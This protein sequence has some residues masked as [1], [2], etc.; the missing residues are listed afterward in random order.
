[1]GVTNTHDAYDRSLD[2]WRR[3][4]DV[5]EGRD[6]VLAQIKLGRGHGYLPRLTNQTDAEYVAYAERAAF[7]N[8][9]GRTLDAFTGMIFAKDPS[10]ELPTALD[11]Y[12]NDITLTA[13]NLREFSEQVV[14]QQIAV[15]RVGIMV[16]YPTEVP[17]SVSVADAE[18]MNLRPFLRLYRAE[19]IINWR[20]ANVNGA[21]VLTLVVLTELVDRLKDEFTV[22]QVV[23]YRVLSLEPDGYRVRVMT[24][25]G[26]IISDVYPL[27]RGAR[28]GF[29]PFVVLGVNSADVDV[30]K[31]PLLD[32]VDTNL[33]HFRNSAD[34]E[35]GLHFTGLP[36]PYVAGI[37][38][39]EG[40]SL[41]VGSTTAWVF[42]DPA[43]KAEFLEFKG[44][45]LGTLR[46]ALKDKEQR[47]AVLGARMLADDKRTAEAFGTIELKTAGERS[48]L[49]SIS[50]AAS[51]AIRR[52]L[53]WMAEW[54]GAPAEVEFALNTDFG[55][56]RMDAQMLT[57]MVGAYQSDAVPMSVL[58]D[59]LQRGEIIRP[60][61]DIET[62]K[63]ELDDQGP[64]F[65]APLLT[66]PQ[67]ANDG[68]LLENI[69]ARL[70]I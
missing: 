28:M 33:A 68:T 30:Q 66:A 61:M 41:S 11:A 16:D 62:Y 49:A 60:D 3:C 25:G 44:D 2:K 65:D 63:A 57:A 36:T 37:Q 13:I 9:T 7:F 19:N 24:D 4:R 23:Q 67:A 70:G 56:H 5:I 1:M 27:M 18:R 8:A 39:D 53:N 15:G 50:R 52:S 58:F 26:S 55:A 17:A 12:A 64:S 47:M 21:Q 46:E 43:A 69:R 51:D 48:V 54:V 29:I 38:L 34:Y 45:G 22:E 35:H 59:N 40:K 42:P 32:L 10:Y 6:A 20:T 14:E 31:P